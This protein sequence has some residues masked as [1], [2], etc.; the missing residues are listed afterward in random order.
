MEGR[1]TILVAIAGGELKANGHSV[2][3]YGLSPS[4]YS[5][6]PATLELRLGRT[7]QRAGSDP[8]VTLSPASLGSWPGTDLSQSRLGPHR[9]WFSP[10]PTKN[11]LPLPLI[12]HSLYVV[13]LCVGE[14]VFTLD[15]D[16]SWLLIRVL[17]LG[18]WGPPFGK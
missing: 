18:G 8:P 17:A 4:V 12:P 9:L 3:M 7:T 1:L 15:I 13:G 10:S 5:F 11:V 16:V 6:I 2:P 14:W